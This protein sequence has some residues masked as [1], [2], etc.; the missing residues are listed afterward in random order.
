MD[1][2]VNNRT[3]RIT[4]DVKRDEQ[5]ETDDTHETDADE[6]TRDETDATD[7]GDRRTQTDKQDGRRR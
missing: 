1:G 5:Q 2:E 6:T 4:Q 3:A 7:A